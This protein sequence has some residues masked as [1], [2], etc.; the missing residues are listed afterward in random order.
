MGLAGSINLTMP[1]VAAQLFDRSRRGL[2]RGVPT[3]G[4]KTLLGGGAALAFAVALLA[5][6]LS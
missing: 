2:D 4:F 3:P 1:V 6:G 5:S